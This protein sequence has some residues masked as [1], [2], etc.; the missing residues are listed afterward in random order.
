M[1]INWKKTICV[2]VIL[3]MVSATGAWAEDPYQVAWKTQIGTDNDDW[4][5]SIAVDALGNAYIGGYTEGD[6]GGSHGGHEAFL[7]KFDSG[8]N[9]VWTTHIGTDKTDL[10]HSIAMD[11]SGSVYISGHTYGDLA[12]A[13][14]GL[15]DVFLLKFDSGGNEV[16]TTQIG[17]SRYDDNYSVAVAAS[18]SIYTSGSRNDGPAGDNVLLSKFDSGGNEIWTT[19]IGTSSGDRSY[20]ISLD[21]SDNAYISGYTGGKLGGSRFGSYDAFLSKFDSGG[22]EVWT[23]QIG[24]SESDVSYSIALDASDNAYISGRTNGDLDG[25]SAGS[26]DAFLSKFDSDGNNLW[27]NQIGTSAWDESMSVA[28]A[29]SGDVYISGSTR[30]DLGGVNAGSNDA[31]L[32]KFDSGG[33]ELWT[34][35]IGTSR[36]DPSYSVAVDASGNAYISGSTAG[37]LGGPNAGG[38]DAFLVKYEVPEPATLVL[39]AGG[40]PFLLK[41]KRVIRRGKG[42]ER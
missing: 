13:N 20:S 34:T 27:T 35:Q 31:F 36:G 21:A 2:G 18:G 17:E 29:G 24:T 5:Q 12:G 25:T 4:S 8:G 33:N 37:D 10:C 15:S 11:A 30:G 6:F 19:Q 26:H 32:S 42:V 41:R 22:N 40:L 7:S 23:T 16:W 1:T 39:M 14:A 28:V 3:V 9:E 38:Y